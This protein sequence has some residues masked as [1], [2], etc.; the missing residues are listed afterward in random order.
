LEVAGR[1]DSLGKLPF[2]L[3]PRR[4]IGL[5]VFVAE[6]L[7]FAQQ[8]LGDHF[9][10]AGVQ[11]HEVGG[12]VELLIKRLDNLFELNGCRHRFETII[13]DTARYDDARRGEPSYTQ[14]PRWL[15]SQGA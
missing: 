10:F 2:R 14:S 4:K 5:P 1:D 15:H 11:I 3:L 13:R 12:L 7:S 9:Q 8:V 6:F